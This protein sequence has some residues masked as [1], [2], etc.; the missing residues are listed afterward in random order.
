MKKELYSTTTMMKRDEAFRHLFGNSER[1]WH[2]KTEQSPHIDIHCFPPGPG[3]REFFTLATAGMSDF[4]M[5]VPVEAPREYPRRIELVFYCTEP[6][7]EYAQLLRG[8]AHFPFDEKTW[9]G[10]GHTMETA[11]I[12]L[13][14]CKDVEALLFIPSPIMPDESLPSA[15]VLDDDPVSLLWVVPITM[16]EC[17]LV[18][19]NGWC[20]TMMHLFNKQGRPYVFDPGRPSCL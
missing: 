16:A 6:R 4:A 14:G 3:G 2:E 8:L 11:S 9:L 12:S 5:N 20:E 13:L 19:E 18:K 7:T 1:V 17:A 15:L 10:P